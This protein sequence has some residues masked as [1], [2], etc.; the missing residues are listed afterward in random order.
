MDTDRRQYHRVQR[1]YS[2]GGTGTDR[3]AAGVDD[4]PQ[5][6]YNGSQMGCWVLCPAGLSTGDPAGVAYDH[7]HQLHYLCHLYPPDV[8]LPD[9][10]I[11]DVEMHPSALP[12]RRAAAVTYSPEAD[13][14]YFRDT[15]VLPRYPGG[16][17]P[18]PGRDEA[19]EYPGAQPLGVYGDAP[20]G[21]RY[22]D[23]RGALR[24]G[25]DPRNR[26]SSPEDQR[27]VPASNA[28]R[29]DGDAVGPGLAD[30]LICGT[31][32]GSDDDRF[33]TGFL[34]LWRKTGNAFPGQ[35]H[36][37]P[38][39]V[40]PAVRGLRL[41]KDHSD[42]ADQRPDPGFYSRMPSGGTGDGKRACA[43]G[44]THA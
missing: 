18:H 42:E 43:A 10:R 16:D 24:G 28:S 31:I 3:S 6:I 8:P 15:A 1:P 20:H 27:R 33:G 40:R 13:R 2:V 41:R 7:R 38:R 34:W 26:K 12:D 11:A 23:G 4:R 14:G 32:R 22:G 25:R 5:K 17:R 21:V 30:R 39:R 36:C 9:D 19:A 44:N 35:R 29:P 37:C